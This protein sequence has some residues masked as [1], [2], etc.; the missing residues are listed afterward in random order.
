MKTIMIAMTLSLTG[1]CWD[2]DPKKCSPAPEF[3]YN[4]MVTMKSGFYKG[5]KG[6]VEAVVGWAA[7][8]NSCSG[9]VYKVYFDNHFHEVFSRDMELSK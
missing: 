4:Q 7:D 9:R 8:E 5:T 2:L 6:Q 3:H 1:C